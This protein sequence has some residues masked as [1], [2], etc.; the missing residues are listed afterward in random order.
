MTYIKRNPLM[1]ALGLALAL[2]VW[3]KLM[4]RKPCRGRVPSGYSYGMIKEYYDDADY[5]ADYESDY[6]EDYEED[7]DGMHGMHGSN[8]MNDMHM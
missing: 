7:Y 8:A 4:Y 6:E 2:M 3:H 1:V 5:D